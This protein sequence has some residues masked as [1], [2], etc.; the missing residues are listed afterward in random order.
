M[1]RAFGR[2]G[3]AQL[4]GIVDIRAF[5]ICL[6]AALVER[7]DAAGG[8]G[9][10]LGVFCL[11]V[12]QNGVLCF[13]DGVDSGAGEQGPG[14]VLLA[15]GVRLARQFQP[16]SRAGRPTL[17]PSS[18][19]TITAA[20]RKM[21]RPRTGNGLPSDISRGRVRMPASV[22]APRTPASEVARSNRQL[23][24]L[25]LVPADGVDTG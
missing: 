21:A 19:S 10:Q 23:V 18:D 9:I 2:V 14:A 12:F 11:D 17:A 16:F 13:F 15:L 6:G 22:I 8:V 7:D 20:A 24:F 1:Q 5:G 4:F 3:L 25:A